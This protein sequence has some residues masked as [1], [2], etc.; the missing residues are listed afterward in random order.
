MPFLLKRLVS[1]ISL[2]L[3]T[4]LIVFLLLSPAFGD[5]A[6]NVLGENAT[7]EQVA[8]LNA[9]L[10]FDQPIFVQYL[11]WIRA[12]LGGDLD[13]VERAPR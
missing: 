10:G 2:V 3:A 1:A 6:R 5:I 13:Y 8:R 4:S 7:A 12:A 9:E 11:D